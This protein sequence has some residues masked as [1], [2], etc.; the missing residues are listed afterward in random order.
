MDSANAKANFMIAELRAI[1]VSD[2]C[3]GNPHPSDV[4]YRPRAV[5]DEAL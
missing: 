4:I 2:I 3:F 5:N 1:G